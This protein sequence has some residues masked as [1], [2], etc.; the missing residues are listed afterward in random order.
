MNKRFWRWAVSKSHKTN[1]RVP[2]NIFKTP[3]EIPTNQKQKFMVKTHI[4]YNF[5][6]DTPGT[7]FHEYISIPVKLFLALTIRL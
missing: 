5:K 3:L 7:P 4:S 2:S 6:P 1:K